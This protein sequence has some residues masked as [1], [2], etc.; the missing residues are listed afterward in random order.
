M[1]KISGSEGRHVKFVN[2]YPESLKHLHP[3]TLLPAQSAV[4]QLF[5]AVPQGGMSP[6]I[7]LL[8]KI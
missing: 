3:V 2:A 6:L 8:P 1:P 7:L 5:I 4:I